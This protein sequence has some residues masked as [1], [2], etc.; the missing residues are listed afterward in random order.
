MKRALLPFLFVLAAAASSPAQAVRLAPDLDYVRPGVDAEA[1]AKTLASGAAVLDL[2]YVTD[3]SAAAPLLSALGTSGTGAG[4][5]LVIALVSP[6]TDPA[7][8]ARLAGLPRVLT[9]GRADADL[10][11][12]IAVNTPADSDRRACDALA[13]GTPPDKLIVEN[14]G[15]LRYD[16]RSLVREHQTGSSEN[17]ADKAGPDA[18]AADAAEPPVIDA[19]LQRAVQVHRGLVTLRKT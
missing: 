15:K 14:A 8:R 19:V 3:R 10:R 5:P 16:E 4:R 9:L 1:A 11:T 6:E 2:R 12:D 17:P 18:G 13:A 7:L